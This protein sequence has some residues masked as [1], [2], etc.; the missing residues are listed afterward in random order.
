M[1]KR[2]VSDYWDTEVQ[3]HIPNF[4]FLFVITY[5]SPKASYQ[6]ETEY[7]TVEYQH[8]THRFAFK[9]DLSEF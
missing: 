1:R 6:Q 4:L 2:W 5:S 3:A 8:S 9:T 7:I